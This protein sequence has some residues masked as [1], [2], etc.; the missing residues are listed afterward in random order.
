LRGAEIIRIINLRALSFCEAPEKLRKF[1]N[2]ANFGIFCALLSV[3]IQCWFTSKS[4]TSFMAPNFPLVL[5]RGGLRN[6]QGFKAPA[7]APPPATL[8]VHTAASAAAAAAAAFAVKCR[9]MLPPAPPEF[10]LC[11][12]MPLSW[13]GLHPQWCKHFGP[14]HRPLTWGRARCKGCI[15]GCYCLLHIRPE[16]DDELPSSVR[17]RLVQPRSNSLLAP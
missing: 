16:A 14:P 7:P 3:S 5:L 1:A 2:F 4:E 12:H 17:F 15:P 13:R 6:L 9:C 11:P 10:Q 8:Q